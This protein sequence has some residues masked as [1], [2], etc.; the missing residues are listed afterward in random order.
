MHKPLKPLYFTTDDETLGQ[1]RRVTQ[2]VKL[3]AGPIVTL[4][5]VV[6]QPIDEV[7]KSADP[8]SVLLILC[9]NRTLTTSSLSNYVT[10]NF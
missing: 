4:Q 1:R 6:H 3:S 9:P 8:L 5:R 7:R 10:T 2:I